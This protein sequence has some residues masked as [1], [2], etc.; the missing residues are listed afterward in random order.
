MRGE[1]YGFLAAVLEYPDGEL[2]ELIREGTIAERARKLVCAVFPDMEDNTDWNALKEV[3]N[4]GDLAVEY[5]R[6]FNL[7]GPGGGPPCPLNSRAYGGEGPFKL[8]E[9]LVRFYNF[10][11]LTAGETQANELPD[12]LSTQFEF[13]HFLCHQEAGSEAEDAE[14]VDDYRRAQRDFLERHPCKWIPMLNTRLREHNAPP[15]YRTVGE[16]LQQ[17]IELDRQ[18]LLSRIA[19]TDGVAP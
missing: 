3:G 2:T 11:G 10:F 8:L 7:P 5:T 13:I 14:T 19:E 4:D 18:S 9:E 1:V 17:F 6:L 12:H 15:F 16:L